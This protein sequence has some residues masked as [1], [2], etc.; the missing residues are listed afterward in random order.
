MAKINIPVLAIEESVI[1]SGNYT[2]LLRNNDT[3]ADIYNTEGEKISEVFGFKDVD[4]LLKNTLFGKEAFIVL[5]KDSYYI[6]NYE[7]KVIQKYKAEGKYIVG[8]IKRILQSSSTSK[9]YKGFRERVVV[10]S[11]SDSYKNNFEVGTRI[12]ISEHYLIEKNKCGEIKIYNISNNKLLG[13]IPKSNYKDNQSLQMILRTNCY[14]FGIHWNMMIKERDGWTVVT[15]D[16]NVM[17][18]GISDELLKM[19]IGNK[20]EEG[21]EKVFKYNGLEIKERERLYKFS[22]VLIVEE[23]NTGKFRFYSSNGNHIV[24]TLIEKRLTDCFKT[25]EKWIAVMIKGSYYYDPE[26]QIFD[27]N[28]KVICESVFRIFQ[29]RQMRYAIGSSLLYPNNETLWIFNFNGEFKTKIEG[30]RFEFEDENYIKIYSS[31][32]CFQIYDLNGIKVTDF[33]FDEENDIVW[34]DYTSII[35]HKIDRDNEYVEYNLKAKEIHHRVIDML[36]LVHLTDGERILQSYP[37]QLSGGMQQRLA[38]ALSLILKPSIVFADE[39]TSALDMLIQAS[40]L[41]LMK[42]VTQ[43]LGATVIIVTHNIKAAARIANSIG[44]M[45]KGQLVEVGSSEEVM[46]HPKDEYTRILLDSVTKVV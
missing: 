18:R 11:Q 28:G 24:T 27:Y 7:G 42:E 33:S 10:S 15:Q 40:V 23:F 31:S 25:T 41:D 43:A 32:G 35:F 37:F 8:A 36:N 2:I 1:V 20:A 29:V 6:K 4:S 38:I 3:K 14:W 26:W 9:F 22:K 12:W 30:Y 21:E 44:V 19:L 45:N 5:S 46:A 17:A 13:T 34:E 39:P 16:G